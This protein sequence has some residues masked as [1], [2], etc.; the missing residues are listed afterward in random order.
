MLRD[1]HRKPQ[2]HLP[3]VHPLYPQLPQH[4]RAEA[5]TPVLSTAAPRPSASATSS[6][7][8]GLLSSKIGVASL[9]AG[10][11]VACLLLAGFLVYKVRSK[12]IKIEQAR[13]QRSASVA[14]STA[15]RS[16]KAPPSPFHLKSRTHQ[17][18][19]DETI[20]S[21]SSRP[22]NHLSTVDT[23][24]R[25]GTS[26]GYPP[27]SNPSDSRSTSPYNLSLL[28]RMSSS[29][30]AV[31]TNSRI[32]M[33]EDVGLLSR[34]TS[35]Q[36]RGFQERPSSFGTG[37]ESRI[38]V[39]ASSA[40]GSRTHLIQP[41]SAIS[42]PAP[43]PSISTVATVHERRP[44][45][46]PPH[47]PP[48][49]DT[50]HQHPTNGLSSI[51]P[52][53]DSDI[54]EKKPLDLQPEVNRTATMRTSSTS[55]APRQDY[56]YVFDTETGALVSSSVGPITGA[57]SRQA[58]HSTT[59]TVSSPRPEALV[60]ASINSQAPISPS[61]P[62]PLHRRAMSADQDPFTNAQYELPAWLNEDPFPATSLR[63]HTS[64]YSLYGG[65]ARSVAASSRVLPSESSIRS[66]SPDLD[67]ASV[68]HLAPP[69]SRSVGTSLR[70]FS[71]S[72]SVHSQAPT[73]L[74]EGEGPQVEEMLIMQGAERPGW[75]QSNPSFAR[76]LS[77]NRRQFMG[78]HFVDVE[79]H[80]S[81]VSGTSIAGAGVGSRGSLDTQRYTNFLSITP[82][83]GSTPNLSRAFSVGSQRRESNN[84]IN[85]LLRG[86]T[87]SAVA[88]SWQRATINRSTPTLV[89]APIRHHES[90]ATSGYEATVWPDS[91]SFPASA[92]LNH[93][94]LP[95]TQVAGVSGSS[96]ALPADVE[97]IRSVSPEVGWIGLPADNEANHP[98][99]PHRP[100]PVHLADTSDR[101]VSR[102]SIGEEALL[103][104]Q[105]TS[106][107]EAQNEQPSVASKPS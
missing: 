102:I 87:V 58:S 99:E 15:S 57:L 24:S 59:Q 28:Q 72:G 50:I 48:A 36:S 34:N 70:P 44:L 100:E 53:K 96:Q 6:H 11:A 68:S 60:R 106:V 7:S 9:C 104:S 29:V 69:R 52:L 8:G 10:I 30:S 46:V 92:R 97:S 27:L 93:L 23:T 105:M 35:T 1:E 32:G 62:Y 25:A 66:I 55:S 78:D 13:S 16:T 61:T 21:N 14:V 42:A 45:P 22:S 20:H 51:Q 54:L 63:H 89:G 91:A 83:T 67:N 41:S 18:N 76:S 86:R 4:R 12:Q 37:T 103:W 101:R 79:V 75:A 98:P 81:A 74:V 39:G 3:L 43:A 40:Y 26:Q 38:S 95:T 33:R 19:R 80:P 88:Q 65:P 77:M 107:M 64:Q 17:L 84:I 73:Q 90:T 85:G 47:P 71:I 31:G 49:Y 2:E 5:G 56:P 82:L 94:P